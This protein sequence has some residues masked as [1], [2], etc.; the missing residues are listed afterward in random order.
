MA[1]LTEMIVSPVERGLDSEMQIARDSNGPAGQDGVRR[2]VWSIDG[3]SDLHSV[4]VEH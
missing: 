1:E 3:N 2:A 4:C